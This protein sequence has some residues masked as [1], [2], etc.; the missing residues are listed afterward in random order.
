MSQRFDTIVVGAGAAGCILAR[1]L[2]EAGQG[3]VLLL[4]SGNEGNEPRFIESGIENLFQSWFTES[5]WQLKTKP[6]AGLGGREVLINQGKV[7]GGGTAINAMMYVRGSRF[8]FEE[9]YQITGDHSNWSPSQFQAMFKEIEHCLGDYG[10]D[11]LRGKN[12]RMSI[13]HPPHPSTASGSFIEACQALGYQRA[14]FNGSQQNDRCDYMQLIIDAEG[15][16]SSTANAYL[17]NDLPSNLT[18]R[19]NSDVQSLLI[20]DGR[21]FGVQLSTGETIEA[22]HVILSAGA[23]QSPGLLMKS[24]VGPKDA[25]ENAGI[26]CKV[27]RPMV[28]QNLSDHMRVMVAYR[29]EI[30]PGATQFLCE[31][32]LFT[33]SGLNAGPETDLQINFSAGV[34]GFVSKEFLPEGGLEHSVIFVPVL[35]RPR[36]RG[37]IQPLKSEQGITFEIDPAYLSDPV[38]LQ[39][40]Q[41]GIEIVRKIAS[42]APMKPYCAEELCPANQFSDPD[43]LKQ[44]ATTI[45]HPVGTCAVGSSEDAVCRPDFSVRGVG[46]LSV[47]DGS[48]LPSLTSGNPQGAIFALASTAVKQFSK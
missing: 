7:L 35:G 9:W 39:V 13:N 48:V 38:D 45:W 33:R 40:Y 22:G 27:D 1:G 25:L 8:N 4:E 44:Y 2:A 17:R 12:G 41:K 34:D 14:D 31:A 30:D 42:S 36:S 10:E 20:E 24:G 26:T 21:C 3:D 5:D 28:G 32:A 47:V 6:Q 16:R 18:I 37:S 15:K 23:L 29:S 19:C 46:Q 11:Q 43:Y